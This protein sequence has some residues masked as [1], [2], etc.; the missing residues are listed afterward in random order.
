MGKPL[1]FSLLLLPS[2]PWAGVPL[3]R[4]IWHAPPSPAAPS[5]L[6]LSWAGQASAAQPGLFLPPLLLSRFWAGSAPAAQPLSFSRPAKASSP[7]A[8]W[9]ARGPAAQRLARPLRLRARGTAAQ[10]P[11]P[12]RV[13]PVCKSVVAPCSSPPSHDPAF[14][15][16]SLAN[17]SPQSPAARPEPPP[18]LIP[19]CGEPLPPLS[20]SLS[21]PSP[22]PRA[23]RRPPRAHGA[24]AP[25]ST[26]RP[27]CPQRPALARPPR[28][29]PRLD[30]PWRPDAL[31]RR[32]ESRPPA[33]ARSPTSLTRARHGGVRPGLAGA[34][35]GVPGAPCVPALSSAARLRVWRGA[36]A[37]PFGPASPARRPAPPASQALP[38]ARPSRPA[39]GLGAA[40]WRARCRPARP[41]RAARP[42]RARCSR[43]QRARDLRR[44]AF[45]APARRRVPLAS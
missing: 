19:A 7:W 16:L 5:R 17:R 38:P 28:P 10:P 27:R 13:G 8:A 4:P 43:S 23:R 20:P 12:L 18:P 31:A 3:L 35:P 6:P 25:A 14:F 24:L 40:A 26:R 22:F 39:P 21:P 2:L 45:T 37:R 1:S 44:G 33:R 30:Q 41:A 42:R 15:S 11:P 36:L 34:A 32:G 29:S 9:L